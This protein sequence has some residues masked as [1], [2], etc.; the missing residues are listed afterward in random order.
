MPICK[1]LSPSL[2][3]GKI[4]SSASAK[5]YNHDEPVG[6]KAAGFPIKDATYTKKYVPQNILHRN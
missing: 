5:S 3:A 6:S 2:R 4:D 1:L